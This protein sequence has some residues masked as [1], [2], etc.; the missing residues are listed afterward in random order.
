[1]LMLFP[2]TTPFRSV[3]DSRCYCGHV[4]EDFPVGLPVA[5]VSRR[6]RI[7]RESDFRSVLPYHHQPVWILEWQRAQK[8]RVH[9]AENRGI[10]TD[11]E[12]QSQQ[13]NKGEP[14]AVGQHAPAIA[15]IL[16]DGLHA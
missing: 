7:V 5:K 4:I 13:C 11:A 9:H 2:S 12:H 10:G 3:L 14:R 8:Y 1:Q 16:P 15:S 6:W